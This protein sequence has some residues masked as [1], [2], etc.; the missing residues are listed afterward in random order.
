MRIDS[1]QHFWKYDPATLSWIDDDMQQLKKDFLPQHLLPSLNE[2][3]IDGCV[4][5][6]CETSATEIDAMLQWTEKNDFIK[7]VVGWIDF[8]AANLQE[9]LD[10]YAEYALL[11]GFRHVVQTEPDNKFLLRKDFCAAISLL[12][13]YNFTYDLLI[14]PSQLPAAIEFVN[15]FPNQK[16][17]LD[18]I[19]KPKILKQETE[20][21]KKYIQELAQAENV[22]CKLSGM[23]TEAD[24]RNWKQSDFTPYIETVFEAFGSKRIMFGSDWPVCLL[25]ASYEQVVHIAENFIAQLSINEQNDFWGNNA[26]AFYNL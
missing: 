19:A 15:L 1:H 4:T 3:N 17:V 24:C 12:H 16:F 2:F 18:H 25:A 21:W 6:Q 9:L 7:G 13:E 10:K 23:V 11:K 5:V 26:T 14:L 8:T 22:Y 20:P